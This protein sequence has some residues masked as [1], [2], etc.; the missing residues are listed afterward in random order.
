MNNIA[1]YSHIDALNT[2]EGNQEFCSNLAK[3][4]EKMQKDNLIVEVQYQMSDN[5]CSV[6]IFGREKY[7]KE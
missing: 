5:R 4:I 3:E 7:E 6:L 1:S 2:T